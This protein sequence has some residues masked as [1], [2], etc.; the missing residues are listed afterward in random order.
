MN[1]NQDTSAPPGGTNRELLLFQMGPVQE[2]IAQ[3]A[4]SNELWAGSYLLSDL[5]LAG[6]KAVPDFRNSMVFPNLKEGESAVLEAME[7]DSVPTIPN[8]FLSFVPSGTGPEVA[9]NVRE[10][11]EEKLDEYVSQAKLPPGSKVQTNQFLQF[12]WAVLENIS[13]DMGK[14]YAAIG[15]L[16]AARRSVREFVPWTE[17]P[18]TKRNGRNSPKDF[19][20]GKETALADGRGSMNLLKFRLAACK[21]TDK[22]PV[23]TEGDKYLAVIALDG[24]KMG[25]ALSNLESED[26]HRE[27][28]KRLAEFAREAEKS[29]EKPGILVYAGG[30]DV[31]AA[32]PAKTAIETAKRLADAFKK[33]MDGF[34]WKDDDGKEHPLSASSGIAVGHEKTPILDLVEAARDAEHRAKNDY[35][36]NALALSVLKRSGE[37]LHWGCNWNSAALDLHSEIVDTFK[38]D[39]SARFPYKLAAFL[40]PYELG[41]NTKSDMEPVVMKEL[42]HVWERSSKE[43]SPVHAKAETYLHETFERKRPQD[44]LNLFLCETFI[45]R[46]RSEED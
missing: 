8:R 3:A 43:N 24:D 46:Q 19:L 10:A 5:I 42:E 41:A 36:R 18:A 45:N 21:G 17:D 44:F 20:S 30:D 33:K 9:R 35:G 25:A 32:V 38:D 29:V 14:D 26:K 34:F 7:K 2:F 15:R 27:F 13:G 4:A 23:Q 22:G 39:L 12:Y 31:L 37:T 16:L 11:I 1:E 40:A 6:I 28:S